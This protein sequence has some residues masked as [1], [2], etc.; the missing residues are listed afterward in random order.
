M[1]V[2]PVVA[3]SE[4]CLYLEMNIFDLPMSPRVTKRMLGEGDREGGH[5]L[6]FSLGKP[7]FEGTHIPK[8]NV[9]RVTL[10]PEFGHL[11]I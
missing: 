1:S 2:L 3:L 4:H 8:P 5:P 6:A 9:G 11:H 10:D 7:Y